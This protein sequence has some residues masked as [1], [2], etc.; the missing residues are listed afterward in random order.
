MQTLEHTPTQEKHG[1]CRQM[2]HTYKLHRGEPDLVV[3]PHSHIYEQYLAIKARVAS[4]S[5]A[6]TSRGGSLTRCP[7]QVPNIA[8][9]HTTKLHNVRNRQISADPYG[10][11][12]YHHHLPALFS[13]FLFLPDSLTSLLPVVKNARMKVHPQPELPLLVNFH[14]RCFILIEEAE[15]VGGDKG[16]KVPAPPRMRTPPLPLHDSGRDEGEERPPPPFPLLLTPPL[17]TQTESGRP[18]YRSRETPPQ[19]RP[20]LPPPLRPVI[21]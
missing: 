9:T 13:A 20:R 7:R 17:S 1:T 2:L 10:T 14:E 3:T 6:T 15:W 5:P 19:S 4:H 21:S 12:A 8:S 16:C 11:T 18:T